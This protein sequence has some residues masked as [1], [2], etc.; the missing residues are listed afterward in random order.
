MTYWET[1][2]MEN[3]NQKISRMILGVHKKASRLATL[4]ELG[5]FPIFIKGL[6]HVM[7][8]YA[9]I[10]KSEGNGS[11]IGHAIKEMKTAHNPTITSWFSRVEK[12][13]TFLGLK[14]STFSK[15]D[16]IGNLIKKQI[17]SKFEQFWLREINK[18]K[19]GMT[20]KT[21]TS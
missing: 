16:V 4:G 5:R 13:K 3:L 9:N 12:I 8:Y 6:C 7:K 17:K 2:K 10:C 1:F 20:I 21:I 18:I 15:I 19:L 11:L 14:Y